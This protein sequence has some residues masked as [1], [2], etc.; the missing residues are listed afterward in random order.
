MPFHL[1]K[2]NVEEIFL[3]THNCTLQTKQ[4]KDLVKSPQFAELVLT[5]EFRKFAKSI[6]DKYINQI[7]K[8]LIQ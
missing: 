4:A 3:I 1:E 2:P 7:T 5:P 8:T 6:A